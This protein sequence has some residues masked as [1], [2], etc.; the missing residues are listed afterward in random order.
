[1][2]QMSSSLKTKKLVRSLHNELI[3]DGLS[4]SSL[5]NLTQKRSKGVG[6]PSPP[7]L[8]GVGPRQDPERS[9]PE[10]TFKSLM[11]LS[12]L[13]PLSFLNPQCF[14]GKGED[15]ELHKHREEQQQEG[16]E[17]S[18]GAGRWEGP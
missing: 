13:Q 4:S 17:V 6:F 14:P 1:M 2:G 18:P 8:P 16:E 15:N 11:T 7:S 5:E 10:K 3:R 9:L 12:A